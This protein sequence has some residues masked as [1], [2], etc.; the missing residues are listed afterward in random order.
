MEVSRYTQTLWR[1]AMGAVSSAPV[2]K[3][4]SVAYFYLFIMCLMGNQRVLL[5]GK[6]ETAGNRVDT[7]ILWA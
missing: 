6:A 7:S 3:V 1:L 2:G 5:G 4:S